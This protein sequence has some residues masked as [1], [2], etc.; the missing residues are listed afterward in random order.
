MNAWFDRLQVA[1][2]DELG[3][4]D[5]LE[6]ATSLT[7]G[8]ADVLL[9]LA[10]DAARTSGARQFAPLTTFLAGRVVQLSASPDEAARK[11]LIEALARAIKAAGPAGS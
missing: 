5:G 1:L 6:E 3:D 10:G 7:A 4:L 2:K 8:E 11:E 9:Q